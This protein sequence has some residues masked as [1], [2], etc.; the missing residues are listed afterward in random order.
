M[1]Q[2]C[3]ALSFASGKGV[4]APRR[5]RSRPALLLSLQD[6]LKGERVRPIAESLDGRR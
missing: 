3:F 6:E 2:N 1:K 5:A 4:S